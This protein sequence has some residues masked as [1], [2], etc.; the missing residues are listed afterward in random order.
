MHC[1]RNNGNTLLSLKKQFMKLL[2]CCLVVIAVTS[3]STV[4]KICKS[5]ITLP[6]V[7]QKDSITF[8]TVNI[9]FCDTIVLTSKKKQ[10][11]VITA[12]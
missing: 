2:F 3:C 11:V 7:F 4:S 10:K 12:P 5:T 1:C 9:P 8:Y 6:V